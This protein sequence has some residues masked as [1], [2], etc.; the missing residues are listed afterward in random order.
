MKVTSRAVPPPLI[1]RAEK[2]G[3]AHLGSGVSKSAFKA[4]DGSIVLAFAF[5]KP[6]DKGDMSLFDAWIKFC[7]SNGS[8][9]VPKF[10]SGLEVATINGVTIHQVKVESLTPTKNSSLADMLLELRIQYLKHCASVDD[11]CELLKG[12]GQ[13]VM[14]RGL[15]GWAAKFPKLVPTILDIA[16]ATPSAHRLPILDTNSDNIMMRGTTPVIT[17]PWSAG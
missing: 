10:L 15:R 17:D 14:S 1:K 9:H 5:L 2:L 8:P 3:F 13:G 6:G 16:K 12:E 11:L 4:P 7:R